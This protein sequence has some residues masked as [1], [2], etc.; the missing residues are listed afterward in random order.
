VVEDVTD[1]VSRI[2]L[3][4][5]GPEYGIATVFAV[6][7]GNDK[8]TGCCSGQTTGGQNREHDEATGRAASVTHANTA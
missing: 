6:R 1:S 2:T 8:F 4:N 3:L 7:V 5:A